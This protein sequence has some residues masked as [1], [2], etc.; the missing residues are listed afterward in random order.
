MGGGGSGD[1]DGNPKTLSAKTFAWCRKLATI[2]AQ[3]G[4]KLGPRMQGPK[5]AGL[6]TTDYG[7]RT[8]PGGHLSLT[9]SQKFKLLRSAAIWKVNAAVAAAV[10]PQLLLQSLVQRNEKQQKQQTNIKKKSGSKIV[11][12]SFIFEPIMT[13]WEKS[14]AAVTADR[15]EDTSSEMHSVCGCECGCGCACVSAPI[16]VWVWLG[17]NRKGYFPGSPFERHCRLKYAFT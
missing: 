4:P 3:L 16:C 15:G 14:W 12:E 9:N 2:F 11:R 10:A 13:V 17:V 5:D 7:L 1:G 6:R 8:T